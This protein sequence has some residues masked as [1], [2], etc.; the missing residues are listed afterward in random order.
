[1][2]CFSEIKSTERAF[3]LP[4]VWKTAHSAYQ[5]SWLIG[6]SIDIILQ[7]RP[8]VIESRFVGQLVPS[9][10]FDAEAGLSVIRETEIDVDIF[11]EDLVRVYT[12]AV[13]PPPE[14]VD[15]TFGGGLL[16]GYFFLY[17]AEDFVILASLR[18]DPKPRYLLWQRKEMTEIDP[19]DD[20]VPLLEN[21]GCQ[22][23]EMPLRNIAA[24][25]ALVARITGR[26]ESVVEAIDISSRSIPV[27]VPERLVPVFDNIFAVFAEGPGDTLHVLSSL[28]K[29]ASVT[30]VGRERD[31]FLSMIAEARLSADTG[32]HVQTYLKSWCADLSARRLVKETS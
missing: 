18:R 13:P 1:M 26:G 2:H 27:D 31:R 30:L 25:S 20:V 10:V 16:P 21:N 3:R 6:P 9:V 29:S 23:H 5:G 17:S 19:S 15:P 4:D 22:G 28:D 8:S 24:V 11:M 14:K 12:H 32:S 7:R